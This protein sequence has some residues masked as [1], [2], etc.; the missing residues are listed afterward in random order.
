MNKITLT[1]DYY[2][3]LALFLIIILDQFLNLSNKAPFVKDPLV[4]INK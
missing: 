1:N 3:I 4:Q 2:S